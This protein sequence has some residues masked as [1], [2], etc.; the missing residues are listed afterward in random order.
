MR[1]LSYRVAR[2]VVA[3]LVVL[4]TLGMTTPP[5]SA[6]MTSKSDLS[7]KIISGP[8]SHLKACQTFKVVYR[9]T[10]HG[11]DRAMNV[12]VWTN[13]PDP[14]DRMKAVSYTHL[15]LPTK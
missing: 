15:T 11:P 7:I 14:V 8:P 2:S 13:T 5:A 4:V 9:V 6:Q 3:I 1:S 10:N 12:N